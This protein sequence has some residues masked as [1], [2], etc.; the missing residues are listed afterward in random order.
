MIGRAICK[1]G[2]EIGV[3]DFENMS[4]KKILVNHGSYASIKS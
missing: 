4:K 2:I 1:N 3:M